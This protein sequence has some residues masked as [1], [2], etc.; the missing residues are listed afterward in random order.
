MH[1]LLGS[2]RS[3]RAQVDKTVWYRKG[4]ECSCQ[5][6]AKLI[7]VLRSLYI[8]SNAPWC[9]YISSA[10]HRRKYLC[11]STSAA[12]CARILGNPREPLE[13][14]ENTPQNQLFSQSCLVVKNASFDH[15]DEESYAKLAVLGWQIFYFSGSRRIPTFFVK[16][17][18]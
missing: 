1:A 12:P 2:G 6:D 14:Q 11:I 10:A 7:E 8:S 13:N 17:G 4:K 16:I 9:L 5:Y 3:V 18:P 15:S